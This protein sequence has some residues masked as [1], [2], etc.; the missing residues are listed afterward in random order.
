[1]VLEITRNDRSEKT[2]YNDEEKKWGIMTEKREDYFGI[3]NPQ[4]N[5]E[6]KTAK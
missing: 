6:E 5:D 3:K 4:S 2:A 1:M